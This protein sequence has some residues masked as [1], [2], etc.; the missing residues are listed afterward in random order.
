MRVVDKP[1]ASRLLEEGDLPQEEAEGVEPGEEDAGDDLADACLAEAEVVAADDGRVD[2]EHARRV[3]AVLVDDVH[4]VGVVLQTLAHLL[5]IPVF[6][7]RH[8][9]G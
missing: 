5:A 2:E 6:V 4:G 7:V 9:E 3:R 8:G 1:A